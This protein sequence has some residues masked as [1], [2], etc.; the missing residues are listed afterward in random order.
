MDLFLERRIRSDHREIPLA[1]IL[2]LLVIV[3]FFLLLSV[4]FV[5]YTKQTLP[6][7][8]VSSIADPLARPPTAP[9]LVLVQDKH[10]LMFLL[11]WIGEKPGELSARLGASDIANTVTVRKQV[12]ELAMKFHERFPE[13]KSIQLGLSAQL[14][15]QVMISALDGLQAHVPDVIL[16]SSV[17]ASRMASGAKAGGKDAGKP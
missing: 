15:Y 16:M 4:S 2:D 7:A 17:D 10:A 14:P 6:P 12:E 5:E 1:P 13:E 11:S 3:I 8:T 9:K